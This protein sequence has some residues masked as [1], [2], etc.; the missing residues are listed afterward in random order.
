[1]LTSIFY[2]YFD[3]P[4][5]VGLT[6]FMVNLSMLPLNTFAVY[7]NDYIIVPQS[8]SLGLEIQFY[9]IIPLILL[10]G[11]KGMGICVTNPVF[12]SIF[13]MG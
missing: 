8:W 13:G 12:T 5:K 4:S 6:Q 10:G 11:K 3:D 1:M 9:I 2:L 7:I